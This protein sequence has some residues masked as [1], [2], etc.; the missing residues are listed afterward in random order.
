MTDFCAFLFCRFAGVPRSLF[1]LLVP[2]AGSKSKDSASFPFLAGW[3][4]Y[5]KLDPAGI[6]VAGY[7]FPGIRSSL[8]HLRS[9][10]F[11]GCLVA[12]QFTGS[13]QYRPTLFGFVFAIAA[14]DPGGR[15]PD[16]KTLGG[17]ALGPPLLGSSTFPSPSRPMDRQVPRPRQVRLTARHARKLHPPEDRRGEDFA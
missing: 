1:A 12:G 9:T 6:E 7:S 16:D 11:P 2:P 17:Q 4:P 8:F 5:L 14:G 13:P 10:R 3:F 15:D